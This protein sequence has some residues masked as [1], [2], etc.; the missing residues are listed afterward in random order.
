[1]IVRR[2]VLLFFAI[3]SAGSVTTYSS[4]FQGAHHVVPYNEPPIDYAENI[5]SD[6]VFQLKQQVERGSVELEYND[7]HG[8]LV[9]VLSTLDIPVESQVLVGSKTSLHREVISPRNPRAVYF[10]DNVYVGWARWAPLLEIISMD[11]GQGS[12]FYVIAQSETNNVHVVRHLTCVQCHVS[13]KSLGVPG[14]LLRSF[15]VDEQGVPD[16]LTGNTLVT[17]ETPLE[18]RWGGFYVTGSLGNQ[19]HMGNLFGLADRQNRA[20]NIDFNNHLT[21]LEDYFETE[22]Y[23]R[24]DSDIAALMVLDHQVHMHNFITR[25][26]FDATLH[27]TRYGHMRY[28]KEEVEA[29]LRYLMFADEAQLQSP[30]KAEGDFV[31]AFE[32]RGPHDEQGRSLR[33]FDLHTRLFRYPVSYL[34]CTSSFDALPEELR[35]YLARRITE[36]LNGTDSRIELKNVEKNVRLAALE[37]LEATKACLFDK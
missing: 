33:E 15:E 35:R 20:Q 27:L 25:L 17:H 37:I 12:R 14:P 31:R 11:P 22:N 24:D 1:M 23:L 19:D 6:P 36:V 7:P 13:S 10:N 4:D 3:F 2:F 26:H 16:D 5:P 30:L 28:L 32:Q 29:F 8:F 21:N 34:I 18:K 9:S